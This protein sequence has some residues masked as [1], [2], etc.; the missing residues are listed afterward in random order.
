MFTSNCTI[1]TA[2]QAIC[3][4]LSLIPYKMKAVQKKVT[5]R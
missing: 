1:A 5:G 4:K 2:L 3:K